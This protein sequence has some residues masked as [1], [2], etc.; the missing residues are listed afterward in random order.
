MIKRYLGGGIRLNILVSACLLGVNCRYNGTSIIH[1]DIR[2][3]KNT[4]NLIPV[5][6]E[7][8][9]GMPTPRDPA[10]RK[11]DK[12]ITSMGE[13]VT[14]AYEKGAMEVLKLAQFYECTIAILKE[15]SP[16]C[17]CGKIHN[18]NFDGTIIDGNGVTAELLMK[19]KITVIGESHIKEYL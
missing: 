8:F 14:A 7:I 3:Y 16:S 17:G 4:H 12:I 18:G 11:V 19:H 10:E 9:G 5:C 6:P 2:I 13:D 1:E 15:R